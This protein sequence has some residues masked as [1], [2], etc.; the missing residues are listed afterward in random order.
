[1]AGS[2]RAAISRLRPWLGR[3]QGLLA[4]AIVVAMAILVVRR[5]DDI[6]SQ[7]WQISPGPLVLATTIVVAALLVWAVGWAVVVRRL[8]AADQPVRTVAGVYIY[9]NLARYLPGAVW[10]LVAR[11]YLGHQQGLG[12]RRIWTAT[13]IDL[14]VAVATGLVLYTGSVAA[15]GP[16]P[17]PSVLAALG[18]GPARGRRSR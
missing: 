2:V 5:W 6:R 4:A 18:A 8:G 13:V 12:Q 14:T 16:E 15:G 17:I 10:N 7:P 3:I 11:A 1:M 9:S